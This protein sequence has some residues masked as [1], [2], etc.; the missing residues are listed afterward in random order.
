MLFQE[1]RKGD[2]ARLDAQGAAT[3]FAE[4]TPKWS[5]RNLHGV[6]PG[7]PAFTWTSGLLITRIKEPKDG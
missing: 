3:L 4:S 7:N 1:G 6:A 2:E 5:H